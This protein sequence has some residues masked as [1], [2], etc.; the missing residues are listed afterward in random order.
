MDWRNMEGGLS[1]NRCPI[2]CNI[3]PPGGFDNKESSCNA[4]DLGSILGWKD[5]LEEEM[6]IHSSILALENPTD[7]ESWKIP[8][9]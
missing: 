1:R 4:G 6:A 5:S 2:L 7:R 9:G 3:E 8:W